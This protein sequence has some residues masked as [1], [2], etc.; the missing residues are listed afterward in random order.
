MGVGFL[1][2]WV[3][4]DGTIGNPWVLTTMIIWA[5]VLSLLTLLLARRGLRS[6]LIILALLLLSPV[7]QLVLAMVVCSLAFWITT[8]KSAV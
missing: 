4:M 1:E 7:I 8:G 5:S 6:R 3:E 2:F